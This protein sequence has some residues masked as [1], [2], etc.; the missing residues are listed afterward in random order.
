MRLA[1]SIHT[2]TSAMQ[3]NVVMTQYFAWHDIKCLVHMKCKTQ[4]AAVTYVN[5]CGNCC[6]VGLQWLRAP[7]TY[8]SVTYSF[9]L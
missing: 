7:S 8:S 5:A 9:Q 6:M 1:A 2:Y 4:N 3:Y